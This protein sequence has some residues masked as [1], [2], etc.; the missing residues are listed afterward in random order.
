MH[1]YITVL[2]THTGIHTRVSVQLRSPPLHNDVIVSNKDNDGME[3]TFPLHEGSVFDRCWRLCTYQFVCMCV[4][5]YVCIYMYVSKYVLE[6]NNAC[7]CVHT[8]ITTGALSVI[9][10]DDDY[11]VIY[12]VTIV[13]VRSCARPPRSPDQLPASTCMHIRMYVYI[14]MH[15]N[16]SV[17]IPLCYTVALVT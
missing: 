17:L 9:D 12:N 15:L 8:P 3:G 14:Y 10:S 13:D 4:R 6:Y 2:L 5:T 7:K 1:V 11:C 16:N